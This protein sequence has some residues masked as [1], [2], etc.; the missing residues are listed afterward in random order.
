MGFYADYLIV[1]GGAGGGSNVGGGGGGGGVTTGSALVSATTYAIVVGSGGSGGTLG[2]GGSNGNLSSALSGTAGGGIGA[3][4]TGGTSGSPQSRAGGAGWVASGVD[5]ASGGG[6]GGASATGTNGGTNSVGG[7]GGSGTTS[8]ITGATITYAGGG[9]G[10]NEYTNSG[11]AGA[12]GAGGGGNGGQGFS[13]SRK[14]GAGGSFF[15]GGGGG[16]G[17]FNGPGGAG[18]RG[19]VILRY[20]GSSVGNVGGTVTSGTGT[21]AGTTLHT[22]DSAGSFSFNLSSLNLN[23]RLGATLTGTISGT[24]GLTYNG[25]GTLTLSAS[26]TYTGPTTVASGT[27]RFG[28]SNRFASGNA[29]AV[30][31][32]SLNLNGFSQ[33]AGQVT[34]TSGTIAGGS[35]SGTSFAVSDGLVSTA[36]SG[37]G[38]LTKSGVGTVTIA[39]AASH[40]G[41]T[42]VSQGTL[43]LGAGGS[44]PTTGAVEVSGGT[45]DLG[46][47]T[48]TVGA[49]TLSSGTI[50]GGTLQPT[51]IGVER[52]TVSAVLTGTGVLT[53]STAGMLL[54]SG[55]NT[56]WTGGAVVNGGTLALPTAASL[57]SGALSVG[58]SAVEFGAR[59]AAANAITLTGAA[60]ATTL[61]GGQV[62]VDYLVVGGG[63]GGGAVQASGG[64]GGGGVQSGA[65][66]LTGSSY[67]V[68]VGVGGAAGTSGGSSVAFGV[69]AT[70]GIAGT[71][72]GGNGGASGSPQ[73]LTGGTGWVQGGGQD[74]LAGGGGAGA[75]VRGNNG[76]TNSVGGN[77]GAGLASTITGSSV[78]Y[79]GGGGGGS[80]YTGSGATLSGTGGAGGGGNGG[81]GVSSSA[82]NGGPATFYG[83]GGGGGGAYNGPGGSGYRGVV[84]VR[85]AGT[86]LASG[87]S[88]TSGTGT[89]AGYTIHTFDSAGS[90]QFTID[91]AIAGPTLSG[92]ISGTGGFT[93]DSDSTLTL[94]GTNTYSGG[95]IV[96]RGAVV[97]TTDSLQGAITNNATVQFAQ[98]TT[99]TYAGVMGGSGAIVKTGVGTLTLTGNN[100]YS[101]LTTISAGRLVGSTVS[102]PGA[103]ANAAELEFA[104][105]LSGTFSAAISGT[106]S[107]T[108]SGVGA[109]TMTGANS[110]SG[111]T[112]IA[113]GTLQV[114]A[115]GTAG[116]LGG[117]GAIANDGVLIIN[118][119]DS[120][121]LGRTIIGAGGFRQIGSGTTT[122]SGANS[123][124]GGTVVSAGRLAGNATSL[125]GAITN[126]ATVEFAQAASGTYA[127]SMG[128]SGALVKT[129]TGVLALTGNNTNAG[130]TTISAGVLQVGDGGTTGSL[131]AG[132][133][134]NNASLVVNRADSLSI[135]GAISGTGSL[136]KLGAGTTTL[137]GGNS[138]TGLTTISAGRLVGSTASLPGTI[139]N[140]AE[141]EFAQTSAGTFASAISGSGSVTKSG[142]GTLT[143]TAA[144]TFSGATTISSGTL[145][146]GDGGTTGSLGAGGVAVAAGAALAFDRSDTVSVANSISGDG[147]IV[148]S[149]G[150]D[151]TLTGANSYTGGTVIHAGTLIASSNTALGTGAV[152]L[153]G[154]ELEFGTGVALANQIVLTAAPAAATFT[155]PFNVEYL[156]VGGGGGGGSIQASGGGGGGGVATGATLL[157]DTSYSI[158]VGAGGAGGTSGGGSSA[159]GVSVGG[160]T[161]GGSNGGNGGASGAPQSLAGGTGWVQGGG[162]DG[163]AGGGGAGAGASGSNGGTNSVG[164]NGGGG[165]ASAISGASIFYAGGGGGGSEYTGSGATLA[166]VGGAGGGGNG[167]LGVNTSAKNGGNATFFGGGGGGGGAFGGPGGSGAGGVVVIRYAGGPVAS[168]GTITSGTNLAAGYTLHTFSSAGA[169]L[170]LIDGAVAGPTLSGVLTGTGGFT[171]DSSLT[172]TLTGSNTY[173]GGTVISAGAVRIGN[174]GGTGS[175]GTGDITNNAALIVDRSNAYTIPGAISGTGS[176]TKSGAGNLILAGTSTFT[177]PTTISTGRLSVNGALGNTAVTVASG[178]ELG[179]SG[180]IVGALAILSGG[181]LAPGNSIASLSGGA[182]SFAAG[183]TFGYEVDSSLLGSL[184]VAADLLVVSGNLDIASGSLLTFTDLASIPQP[185][186]NNTS[187]ALIN[188]SGSWNGGLFSYGGIPLADGNQFLV[189]SQQWQIDYNSP[190]GGSNY[191]SDYLPSSSFVTVMAV[192]EPGALA[193]AVVGVG[194]AAFAVRRRYDP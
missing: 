27:L 117:A 3:T 66:T 11:A 152:T 83:G 148:K 22:Y 43:A 130:S 185:F 81:L 73:L 190:T 109:L 86:P 136:T 145:R 140:A 30:S 119:S 17:G 95:T 189:G 98:S 113:A 122:L 116:E 131:G 47:S 82:K 40:S 78:F 53:K 107:F 118:R 112:T 68:A 125:Q 85:Y 70:G 6:G 50:G 20:S 89:A 181:T 54:L 59:F 150:G 144:N 96:A 143:L 84:I 186:V 72:L 151:L 110:Y 162:Q 58:D 174:G 188:Y 13:D 160:G 51:S 97:G 159:L 101:G 173:G 157:T 79:A 37:A 57:G 41:G 64:G 28:G 193:L 94:G 182:T 88:I 156:V 87:G 52:G 123:Y 175:L 177:G 61:T 126:D 10:G 45:L 183:S 134:T 25:P 149:G 91:G 176:L 114:G 165:V 137:S 92:A 56:S 115:G 23:S 155:S 71:S 48:A 169:G 194:L 184:G 120:F 100:T 158:V 121:S 69:T 5:G 35:L 15:G 21:A 187:F 111:S 31:G 163:L 60:S 46:G 161:A 191:T 76:G 18:Y 77:G 104:Q 154:G 55:S 65:I 93:W 19:V 102:L 139:A 153:S 1:G 168:G 8:T 33:T 90:S 108:K 172:L 179:G 106:G 180:S 2:G 133:I 36:L 12:G 80:E 24:G 171:W 146:I 7:A 138:Y 99:G 166:G 39:A 129:G 135:T 167:G 16:G 38:M 170:F 74:G 49:V 164:G 132:D 128:G 178:A 67:G 103:I 4:R 9:G 32:G 29:I 34:L 44:L 75:G 142:V 62:N 124:S 141:L 192:P 63:G 127:G 42:R 147:V 105:A 26:N 14:N